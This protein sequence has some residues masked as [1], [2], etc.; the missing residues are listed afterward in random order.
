M[1]PR[2]RWR[3]A[4]TTP[5]T[6]AIS[7]G[8]LT[9]GVAFATASPY[10]VGSFQDD[11]TYVILGRALATGAGYRYLHLPGLPAA[12]HFPPGYPAY[13][14]L[15]WRF[16]PH[17]PGNVLTFEHGN[18]LLLG[19]AAVLGF[20]LARSA[21]LSTPWACA[22]ALLGTISIPP[23]AL[24][25]MVLSESAFLAVVL[26]ALLG[27]ER[28]AKGTGVGG[29][30]SGVGNDDS[31]RLACFAGVLCG[32]VMLVRS[33][34]GVLLPAA[35]G[36]YLV[37]RQWRAA[38]GFAAGAIVT[39]LPWQLWVW[40]HNSQLAPI[41]QGEYGSYAAWL[42]GPIHR[43]GVGFAWDTVRRKPVDLIALFAVQ[44]A[45][46]WPLFI[47]GVALAVFAVLL[48][49][50]AVVLARRL[51]VTAA[52]GALYF[53]VVLL[54][55]FP[56]FRFVWAMWMLIVLVLAVAAESIW[57]WRPA[58]Q[59]ARGWRVTGLVAA[60]AITLC[61]VRYDVLG[62][63][64]H[65]WNTMQTSL[66]VHRE[67]R[68]AWLADHPDLP[69]PTASDIEPTLYLYTGRVGVPCS[70]FTADEFIY[71]RDTARDRRVLRGT[72]DQF[73]IGSVIA[74]TP[75]CALAAT[76]ISDER[77]PPLVAYDTTS[78]ELMIFVRSHS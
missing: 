20:F 12:T 70:P 22:V 77:R 30:R 7:V 23:L 78:T 39:V 47:K 64:H 54:W 36:V 50:G 17:F 11:G 75:A 67:A 69:G 66:T 14:A 15:L 40:T 10:M 58:T 60:A 6:V 13:L 57:K 8:L 25:S 45:P 44:L 74:S 21:R 5:W 62:Y 55:P 63:R 41:L 61:F 53:I 33:I 32:A 9:F 65:W 29:R 59:G 56:P 37:R 42:M 1:T 28:I 48:A 46:G 27:A 51:P 43:H 49:Y 68:L 38:L 2:A 34:G 73:P 3:R 18:D 31:F 24:A 71:M 19:L 76:R 4:V 16:A 35:V 52:F 26:A 72:L